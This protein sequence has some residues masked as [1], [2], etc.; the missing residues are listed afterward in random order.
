M[1]LS[2][3]IAHH[4]KHAHVALAE[5]VANEDYSEAHI[6]SVRIETLE[7]VLTEGMV[8]AEH[9]HNNVVNIHG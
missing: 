6:W 9:K 5:A 1:D 3:V 7:D 2:T 4:L 8:D